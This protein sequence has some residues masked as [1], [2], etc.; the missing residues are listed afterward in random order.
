MY[1]TTS[2]FFEDDKLHVHNQCT[3]TN[4]KVAMTTKRNLILVNTMYIV[5]RNTHN[6]FLWPVGPSL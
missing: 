4:I 1:K 5:H 6:V 2:T 3:I